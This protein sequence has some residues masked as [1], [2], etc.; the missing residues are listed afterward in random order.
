MRYFECLKDQLALNKARA[1]GRKRRQ[2]F[3]PGRKPNLFWANLEVD[4]FVFYPQPRS[5]KVDD[6]NMAT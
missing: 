4:N 3:Q 6:K 2:S 1:R 5:E